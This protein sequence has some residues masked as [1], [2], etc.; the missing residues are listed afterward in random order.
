VIVAVYGGFERGTGRPRVAWPICF[1]G[2]EYFTWPPNAF[3][4]DESKPHLML[5]RGTGEEYEAE[6]AKE[7]PAFACVIEF[8]LFGEEGMSEESRL[9]WQARP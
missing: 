4:L 1:D 7:R 5:W 3:Q 6:R 2:D 8:W 9:E